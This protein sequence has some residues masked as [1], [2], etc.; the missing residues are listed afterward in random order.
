M[1]KVALN[2]AQLHKE[3][4][5]LSTF[6]RFLPSLDLKRRQLVAELAAARREL[7]RLQTE[8]NEV[9]DDIGRQVPMLAFRSID[10]TGLVRVTE[11]E[12]GEENR[13]G[14]RLP[15]LDEVRFR[16]LD[17]G[18]LARPH[19]VDAVVEALERAARL[20][21]SIEVAEARVGEFQGALRK[22]T[23]RVNLFEQVLIPEARANI[24]RIEVSLADAERAAVVRSKIAKRKHAAARAAMVEAAT[25]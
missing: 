1:A 7:S 21:L 4:S 16:V 20:R 19:W 14:A 17:Y 15:R 23:Q 10:L 9:E 2:K 11:V 25:G 24:K 8:A 5:A 18:L 13:L 12:L 6:R 22:T 3:Q